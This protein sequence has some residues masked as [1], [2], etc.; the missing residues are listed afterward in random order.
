MGEVRIRTLL[1]LV[2]VTALGFGSKFYGGPAKAWVNNS[3]S[4]VFY[5]IFWCLAVFLLRPRLAPWKIA[6]W[7]L[8]IT[9]V[10]EF[11]QLWHPPPLEWARRHVLG[12]ALLGNFF[13][14]SDF[15]YYVAGAGT[16]WLWMTRLRHAAT[17]DDEM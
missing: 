12:R 4:G 15:P 7:V 9:C 5:E 10:L 6:A 16:G 2:I 14:W 8:G 11:M 17:R 3:L 13:V 1:W